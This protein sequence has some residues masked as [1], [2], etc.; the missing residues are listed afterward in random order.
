VVRSKTSL[1]FSLL[2]LSAC[3][4]SQKNAWNLP[5]NL[6]ASKA[7]VYAVLGSPSQ[8]KEWNGDIEWFQ[9]SGLVVRYDPQGHVSQIVVHGPSNVNFITFRK[10]AILGLKVTDTLSHFRSVLGNPTMVEDDPVDSYLEEQG[11]KPVKRTKVFK[12]RRPPYFIEVLAY[13]ADETDQGRVFRAGT[14]KFVQIGKAVG[15]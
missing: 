14:I 13:T 15:E 6:G 10:P 5:I 7:E 8:S 9:N 11:A 3:A 1:I 4:A 2:F 12:W